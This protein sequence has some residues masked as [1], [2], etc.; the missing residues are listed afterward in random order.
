MTTVVGTA[1][2][3]EVRCCGDFDADVCM[4]CGIC[5]ASCPL[6]S[7]LSPRRLFR[8]VLLGMEDRLLAETEDVY[9]CLLCGLCEASCPAGVRIT[10]NVR[11]LRRHL[12][13]AAF[14]L[15]GEP[16]PARRV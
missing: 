7:G 8:H 14:G 10:E 2:L 13:R 5:T 16:E 15:G 12:N 1:L 3:D 9:S 4:S 6:D 11:T